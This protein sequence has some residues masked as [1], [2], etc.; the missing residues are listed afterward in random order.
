MVAS[1]GSSRRCAAELVGQ[2]GSGPLRVKNKDIIP[3]GMETLRR[4]SMVRLERK[5]VSSQDKQG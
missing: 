5:I 1:T 4:A 2:G 3:S